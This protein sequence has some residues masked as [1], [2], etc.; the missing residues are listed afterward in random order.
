MPNSYPL[1]MNT[2]HESSKVIRA[3][4]F[5]FDGTL[6][7]PGS[8]DFNAVREALGC[9]KGRPV[10]EFIGDLPEAERIEALRILDDFE[11]DAARRSRPNA[12]A[13]EAIE[14]LHSRGLKVGI[15]SRNSRSSIQT[16]LRNFERVRPSDFM[17]IFSRDDPFLP[18]P[19]PESILAAADIL[20][21][22]PAQV[23]VVGDFVFDIDA[24][25]NAGALTAYLTNQGFSSPCP[26]P[27]DFTLER[28]GDLREIVACHAPLAAGKLP[29]ELLQRFLTEIGATDPS[30]LL[31]PGIG[32][33]VAAVPISG[34]EV[35]VLKSD[36]IT[37]AT[38]C[39]GAYAVH[40]NVNDLVTSGATPRW[41]TASLLF[42]VGTN[43]AQVLRVMRDLQ[44]EARAAGI[45]LC[46]GHTEVTD[47]VNRPVIA[48]QAVGTVD[49]RDLVDK[50]RM[51]DGDRVLMT[52]KLAV[53]GTSLLAREVPGR[54]KE[55]GM[56]ESEIDRCRDFL[57][58]PGI[59]VLDEAR[60][61]ARSGQ[62]SAMHDVTEGGLSTAV[63]ELGVAGAHR[64]R[65]YR[66]LIP[67]YPETRRICSLL[68]LDPLG[69][70]GSGSLLITCKCDAAG[71][72]LEALAA[73]GVDATCVGE[74]LE[75]GVGVEAVNAEGSRVPWPQFET[76]E[77][78]RLFEK[79]AE[80]PRPDRGIS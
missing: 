17:V 62:V 73:A 16:A 72:L 53:E 51:T 56:E 45:I 59:S 6:T 11:T 7:Q 75:R 79:T 5:D 28:M 29:N 26:L 22:P 80:D 47:A 40:V 66:D 21:V 57:V 42:P 58:H 61:A 33:D 64:I 37:F 12:G 8:L 30:L 74:V 20:G 13:E 70:I 4:L 77:I 38:D 18:K 46:G 39:A 31:A 3:V 19:S 25:R 43:A 67:V 50:R 71:D 24:G 2:V 34:E 60:I 15:I 49:R 68:N 32:E 14:F 9:P 78:A 41:L 76:D 44:T 63:Y 69:L 54:L 27:P 65:V 35:L 10:L 52:K 48:A 55:L 23:L 1:P 36:P